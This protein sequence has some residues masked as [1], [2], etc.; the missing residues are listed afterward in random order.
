V[1]EARDDDG[2]ELRGAQRQSGGMLGVRLERVDAV[3]GGFRIRRERAQ[4][5]AVAIERDDAQASGGEPT[6]VAPAAAREIEDRAA[7][8]RRAQ[9][10]HLRDHE[11]GRRR[12]QA[13]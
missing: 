11:R 2:A 1:Q 4:G 10:R 8:G 6:R 3:G 12:H 9:P 5:R 7:R 13:G